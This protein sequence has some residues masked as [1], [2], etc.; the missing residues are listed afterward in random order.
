MGGFHLEA[1]SKTNME[2]IISNI[3]KLGVR[4]V[5]PCHCT[6]ENAKQ[7]FQR[8]YSDNSIHIGAGKVINLN[9]LK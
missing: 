9:D 1:E 4:Y 3:R 2:K 8:V 6:G 7:M 5:G